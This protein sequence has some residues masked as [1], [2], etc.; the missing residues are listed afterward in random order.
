MFPEAVWG[1]DPLEYYG[2]FRSLEFHEDAAYPSSLGLNGV[3]KWKRLKAST[4]TPVGESVISN[5]TVA[6]PEVKWEY[7]RLVYGWASLQYQ[8]WIRG[9]LTLHARDTKA[10]M[11]SVKNVLE[12]R[13]DGCSFFGG[14]FYGFNRAPVMMSLDPGEHRLDIRLVRDVRAMGGIGDPNISIIVEVKPSTD[15]LYIETGKILVPEI[16]DGHSLAGQV[17]SVPIVN[18]MQDWVD[19][20]TVETQPKVRSQE[21]NTLW[22]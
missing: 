9:T 21:N 8:A 6:W 12:Y 5:V 17:G 14:D 4:C 16:I 3:V 1:A 10:I 19:V 22:D 13:L 15:E 20:L 11:L 2:G 7:Q 18:Q